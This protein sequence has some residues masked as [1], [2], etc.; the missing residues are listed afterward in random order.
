MIECPECLEVFKGLKC[1]CGYT[2]K[3]AA[4]THRAS[5]SPEHGLTRS[6]Q[7]WL[8]SNGIHKAGMTRAE[9]T[10]ANRAYMKRLGKTGAKAQVEPHAWA[11]EIITKLADGEVVNSWAEKLARDVTGIQREELRAAA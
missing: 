9:K 11:Y 7:D 5:S 6:S 8:L 3:V 2:P 10:L 4:F 1:S